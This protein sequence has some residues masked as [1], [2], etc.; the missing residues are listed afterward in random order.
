MLQVSSNGF[1]TFGYPYASYIPKQFPISQSLSIVAPFWS[2][3]DISDGIG[4]I[5]Y[6]VY[7][8]T[9]S[10]LIARANEELALFT[11]EFMI[12]TTWLMVVTWDGVPQFLGSLVKVRN[13]LCVAA[14]SCFH[15]HYYDYLCSST[16]IRLCWHGMSL[17]HMP[18][19]TMNMTVCSGV[20]MLSLVTCLVI[21][22]SSIIILSLR[23]LLW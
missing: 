11:G 10:P 15:L 5:Y 23:Q 17:T 8:E 21:S 9:Q 7:A 3:V 2:D 14:I 4:N 22:S 20:A 16:P 13:D 6:H 19:L 1:I 12:N 18:Y